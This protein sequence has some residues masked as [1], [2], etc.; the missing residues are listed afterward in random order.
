MRCYSIDQLDNDRALVK[1]GR[2]NHNKTEMV[3]SPRVK[4]LNADYARRLIQSPGPRVV[5]IDATW[6]MP[7]SPNNAK[8]QFAE[9]DRI[10]NSVFFD[11]DSVCC[12]TSKYPHMLP[13]HRLFDKEVG[14]L[15][16]RNDD[17]LLVY[18]RQG[19]FS[20]PRA[21]WTFAL[22]GHHNV[23]L[24]DHYP[25][26]KL[27][28]P[29]EN[30]VVETSEATDN[31]PYEGIDNTQ[32]GKNYREQVIEFDELA[33]LVVLRDLDDYYV[34]D[35][36]SADRFHGKA[37]EPRKGLLSGH[38][39]GALNL[40]FTKVLNEAG[41]YK[42]VEELVELFKKDFGL[43]WNEPLDRKGVIVMCGTGVTAVILR[44][45]IEKIN[46]DIPIR[47][48]DGSWTE[49]AQRAPDLIAEGNL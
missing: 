5:P 1:S 10:K 32:F 23:Y 36:R 8:K 15:G 11:L 33:D 39:P 42:T 27:K 16:I 2:K 13:P 17:L 29:V 49:W 28:Y 19:I 45:A 3:N 22:Y 6:Y 37:P 47:V 21:A 31:L 35:A 9:D 7:N 26:Y 34:F 48:Y 40:P 14:K 20:G 38:I 25:Q 43:D 12:R 24:L 4:L 44:L 41:Q 46:S 18:D 30:G